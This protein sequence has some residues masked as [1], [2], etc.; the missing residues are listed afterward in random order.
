MSKRE[1]H[2]CDRYKKAISSLTKSC[3]RGEAFLIIIKPA[4]ITGVEAELCKECLALLMNLKNLRFGMGNI[5]SL[6]ENAYEYMKRGSRVALAR[7]GETH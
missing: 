6:E 2:R 4:Y 7:L 3:L 1:F 5:V